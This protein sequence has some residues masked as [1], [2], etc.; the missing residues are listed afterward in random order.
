VGTDDQ[1]YCWG[2][3]GVGQLG[4]GTTPSFQTTPV[5]VAAVQ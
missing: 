2:G 5:P 3:G 4:N 1:V